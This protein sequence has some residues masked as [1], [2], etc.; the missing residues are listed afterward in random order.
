MNKA[1]FLDRDGVVNIEIN[2]L[3]KIEDFIFVDGIFELCKH[4]QELGYALFVVTNQSGIA[5]GYYTDENFNTLTSWMI[6]EFLKH[7]IEIKK[8]YYCPHFPEISGEC[9][10]RKPNSGMLLQARNEFDID[11]ENSILIG[12]KESDI[13]AAIGAGLKE[14]YLFDETKKVK[15]SRATKIVSSL[16]DIYNVNTK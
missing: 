13:E 16:K 9:S 4:Y 14:S 8:T 2:Y 12:D 5:R 11:L 6:K 7:S 3:Y 10:C 15:F 1:L